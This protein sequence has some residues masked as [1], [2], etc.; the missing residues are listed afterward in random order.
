MSPKLPVIKPKQLIL[1]LKRGGFIIDRQKGSHI[2]MIHPE[3]K[4]AVTVSYHNKDI[5]KGLLRSILR[6][7]DLT[8][9][10]FIELL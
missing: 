5:K 1:A 7:A 2:S 4:I 9:E 10:E 8:V 3:R 6:D